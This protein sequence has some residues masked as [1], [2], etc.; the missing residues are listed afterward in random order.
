MPAWGNNA[1]LGR[2]T[3]GE[4]SAIDSGVLCT[5][6]G[7]GQIIIGKHS[8]IGPMNILDYS[9]NIT[10]G[11][12]VHMA[13]PRHRPLDAHQRADV[14]KQHRPA[15]KEPEHPPRGPH[16]GAQQRLHW[17][18]GDCVSRLSTI[19]AFAVV[20]PGSV[21]TKDVPAHTM[22]GGAPAKFIKAMPL[23]AQTPA[24]A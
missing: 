21:V 22:V 24:T 5:G 9:A 7:N 8:Y 1:T 3:L 12:Y 17:R 14:P 23:P 2:I 10:I 11:D 4:H 13:E 19:G 15:R 6:A 18:W 16:H 20:A